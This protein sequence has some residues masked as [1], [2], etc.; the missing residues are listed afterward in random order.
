MRSN[1][2]DEVALSL[3]YAGHLSL[4]PRCYPALQ[5]STC[6]SI[7]KR[8]P[9]SPFYI[10]DSVSSFKI[11]WA[12]PFLGAVVAGLI[13]WLVFSVPDEDNAGS[14]DLVGARD[15]IIERPSGVTNGGYSTTKI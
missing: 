4:T 15:Y 13:Y 7:V 12:G 1:G 10:T 11:Y 2:A 9:L 6:N 5:A 8:C 14:A 3:L